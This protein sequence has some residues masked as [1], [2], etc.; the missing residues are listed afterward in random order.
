MSPKKPKKRHKK[1]NPS[2]SSVVLTALAF[3]TLALIQNRF[4]IFS[5]IRGFYGMH[6]SDGQNLWPFASKQLIGSD[7]IRGPVEYPALTGLVMWLISFLIEPSQTAPFSY[8]RLTSFFQIILFGVSAFYVAKLSNNRYALLFAITPA[9]LYSLNRNWDIW[10]VLPMLLA[11]YFYERGKKQK[12]A[13]LLGLSIATK[14]FPIV[15]LFP[16]LIQSFKKR[17]LREALRYTAIVAITWFLINLPFALINFKGWFYFYEFSF[18]RGLGS[19]SI[20]ELTSING[21]DLLNSNVVYYALNIGLFVVFGI[22]LLRLER[23]PSLGESAFLA[24]FMFMLFNKQYSMQYIIWLTC[25]CVIAIFKQD[26][27]KRRLLLAM[28]SLWQL[29]ELLF[30]YAFFQNIL[31]NIYANTGTPASPEISKELY[32]EIGLIRY[33]LAILFVFALMT[34]M[35]KNQ[36][37]KAN[38]KK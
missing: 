38:S 35:Y 34:S 8:F 1:F 11:V 9:V 32:A 6:F 14:F 17:E 29:F 4:G 10:A 15:L 33:V 20:Y 21:V 37:V 23:I 12:S 13:I 25:L 24:M 36:N 28:F 31:T 19:A 27:S 26:S 16:I 7:V 3:G 18:N 22:F 5:D 2:N 30:Q